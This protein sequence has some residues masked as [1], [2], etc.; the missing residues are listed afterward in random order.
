MA[1]AS[2]KLDDTEKAVD[3][4]L[5]KSEVFYKDLNIDPASKWFYLQREGDIDIP[6]L[7][8]DYIVIHGDEVL[9]SGDINTDIGENPAIRNEIHFALNGK[10]VE[11]GLKHAKIDSKEICE[12]DKELENVK[13]FV[14]VRGDVDDVVHIGIRLV[15]QEADSYFTIPSGDDDAVDVEQCSKHGRRPPK[16]QK[17]YKIKVDRDKYKV[18]QVAMTGSEILELAGKTIADWTLNQKLHGG[19]R[20]PIE[21][22]ESVDFSE[23]GIERFETVKKQAQQGCS[24]EF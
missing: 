11:S 12:M 3:K 7:P 8:D 22:E 1:T 13:L 21:P 6:L 24:G 17:Y 5:C 2:I 4:G 9:V 20:K 18:K 16:G 23:P 15:V 14:D 10:K 19:R